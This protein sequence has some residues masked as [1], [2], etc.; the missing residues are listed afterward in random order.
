VI[1][2]YFLK[3]YLAGVE[4]P[5]K[6]VFLGM[7]DY[8]SLPA[9]H[10]FLPEGTMLLTVDLQNDGKIG[11]NAISPAARELIP[12]D[13]IELIEN[14]REQMIKGTWDPF[15]EYE[16]VS[17]GEGIEMPGLPVPAAGTV[18]KPAGEMPTDEFLLGQLNFQLEGIVLVE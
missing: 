10:P 3:E 9:G 14:R 6:L 8:I 4:N 11:V 18:V 7:D 15:F 12:D 1:W 2:D 5:D 16:L 17:S 13:V